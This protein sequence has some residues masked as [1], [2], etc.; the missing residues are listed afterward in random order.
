MKQLLVDK[1]CVIG[2]YPL[3]DQMLIKENIGGNDFIVYTKDNKVLIVKTS[4]EP[5]LNFQSSTS[6]YAIEFKNF[7]DLISFKQTGETSFSLF[8]HKGVYLFSIHDIVTQQAP[9]YIY[10]IDLG[11]TTLDHRF[12]IVG[13]VRYKKYYTFLIFD[14]FKRELITKNVV[15]EIVLNEANLEYNLVGPDLLHI[16]SGTDQ[17]TV[18]F[19]KISARGKKI[20]EFYELENYRQLHL[21]GYILINNEK[22]FLHNRSSGVFFTR[23]NAAKVTGYRSN[24]KLRFFGKHLY[25]FGRSTHYAYKANEK[26]DYLYIG[27]Q[28]K[29][30][31]Q[32]N[33]PL[34]VRLFRRY[35]YFKIPVA[36]L[37]EKQ[38]EAMNIFLGNDKTPLHTL[39]LKQGRRKAGMITFKKFDSQAAIISTS[40]YNTVSSTITSE[41][42]ELKLSRR[43]AKKMAAFKNGKLVMWI[44]RILFELIGRMPKK[45]KLVIF[46]SF[47]AK[48]FSDN[49]RAIYEYMKEHHPDYQLLW[50]INSQVEALFKGFEVPYVRRFTIR[51]FMTFPRAKYWVNNVR[52]PS[53]MP[54]PQETIFVQTWHGTPLKKL[55]I[56]IEEIHMPGTKTST[57]KKNFV[58]ESSKWDYLVSP[59]AYSTEIFKRAFHFKGRVIESGYPRNDVLSNAS[60][61][62]I[63]QIRKNLGIPDNKKIML[64]APTWRD[65]EFYQK[66]KYK[67]QFQFDLDKWKKEFGDDWV[68]LSRMHYL[69]AENFDFSAHAGTVY[70][71]SAYPDIRDLYLVSDMMITDYS[72]VFFDYAILNRPII[73][74]MYDLE[75][76]QNELR[77]FYINIEEDAPGPIVQTEEELFQAM[78][79]L[80]HANVQLD[81][82]FKVFRNKF[83]SLEDGHATERV[84][85]SFLE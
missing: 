14:L 46:E 30:I 66:G 10:P 21:L 81:P 31:S 34:K 65:N 2:D 58:I 13:R 37:R 83:A 80:M 69:I 64:Y 8:N 15:F 60:S 53:W 32:F 16:A 55:G 17:I 47:H 26:Y 12:L 50:S 82:K 5:N 76:Y 11:L 61:E 1:P 85:K 41:T 27:E 18:N 20:F 35:G 28:G 22:Y 84:V 52:L 38:G 33:R 6:S 59:N 74:F 48:Q 62:A 73:F 51:W 45:Q 70:D 19:T 4:D 56:D 9:E 39:K 72:S 67:F 78:N 63:A 24:M 23:G 40:S 57:Y 79:E 68:L 7:S 75:K 71:V 3:E 54:K 44:I 25:I 43:L 36:A 77:G 29:P 49:P 42:E